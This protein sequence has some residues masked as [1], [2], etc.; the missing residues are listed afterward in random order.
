MQASDFPQWLHWIELHTPY[1]QAALCE[2]PN[3]P[4]ARLLVRFHLDAKM[5]PLLSRLAQRVPLAVFACRPDTTDRAVF[6]YLQTRTPAQ[7]FPD[8]N[9]QA[10]RDFLEPGKD[11][12]LCDLGGEMICWA[13]GSG[14]L[15]KQALEGTTSGIN[16][17][18]SH[19]DRQTLTFPV[20]DWNKALLKEQIHNEKMVGFSIWQTFTQVT[21]LSLHGK[22]VGVLGFGPVGRGLARTARALGGMVRVYDK[23]EHSTLL[24]RFEGFETPGRGPTLAESEVLVT[25]TGVDNALLGSDLETLPP[26]AILLNAGHSERELAKEIREHPSRGPFLPHIDRLPLAGRTVYLL[27]GGNLLNLTA[28]E[29]DTINAFDVTTAVLSRALRRLLSQPPPAPGL[30]RLV[31]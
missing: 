8:W 24:A 15:F 14:L 5:L 3:R 10:A 2:L 30:H 1:T 17:I 18:R 31:D 26:G 23:A 11:A 20:L 21:R 28:G 16:L 12:Y 19:L 25:A 29:G 9:P 7:V 6:E 13:M 27:A 4:D 22:K